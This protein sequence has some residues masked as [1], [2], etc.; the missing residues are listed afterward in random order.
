MGDCG[1]DSCHA[2]PSV[3]NLQRRLQLS[4][5]NDGVEIPAGRPYVHRAERAKQAAARTNHQYVQ[6]PVRTVPL[7]QCE[8]PPPNLML[9]C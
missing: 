8:M 1:N 3:A 7:W 2:K 5:S 4:G 9:P 6:C